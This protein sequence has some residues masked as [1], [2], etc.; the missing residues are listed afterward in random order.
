MIYSDTATFSIK[1]QTTSSLHQQLIGVIV[2]SILSCWISPDFS[3]WEAFPLSFL[4]KNQ[5]QLWQLRQ[6]NLSPPETI[7]YLPMQRGK[8]SLLTP[9]TGQ[10]VGL[11]DMEEN[12]EIFYRGCANNRKWKRA[13]VLNDIW[14][15]R[16]IMESKT[17]W[18]KSGILPTASLPSRPCAWEMRPPWVKHTH[19]HT[20]LSSLICTPLRKK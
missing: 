17:T 7:L 10:Q 3:C 12:G 2:V 6:R 4:V 18:A 11:Q 5:Q 20:H 15:P 9:T 14:Y 19:T 16:Q 13:D 8:G 1:T